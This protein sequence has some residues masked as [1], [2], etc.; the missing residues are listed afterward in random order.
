MIKCE[1]VKG[2]FRYV[3]SVKRWSDHSLASLSANNNHLCIARYTNSHYLSNLFIH[4][5]GRKLI[6]N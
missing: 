5:I 2:L 1:R 3:L 6:Y 4:F